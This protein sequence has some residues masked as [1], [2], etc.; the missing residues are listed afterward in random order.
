VAQADGK[1]NLLRALDKTN[2]RVV[3]EIDLPLRPGGTP[4]TYMS[5]G[6]QYIALASGQGDAAA[7]VV[8]ALP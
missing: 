8:V 2:G 6:K 4:M 7:L 1:R 3:A 5:G